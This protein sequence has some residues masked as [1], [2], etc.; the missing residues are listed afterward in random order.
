MLLDPTLGGDSSLDLGRSD[1][2]RAALFHA[3]ARTQRK[4][5]SSASGI[6]LAVIGSAPQI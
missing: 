5:L 3:H 1:L 6:G 2:F 4:A